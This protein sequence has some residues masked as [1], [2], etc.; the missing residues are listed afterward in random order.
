MKLKKKEREFLSTFVAVAQRLLGS[1]T[2][3]NE[4][5]K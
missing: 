4:M 2:V 5:A 1:P 3:S